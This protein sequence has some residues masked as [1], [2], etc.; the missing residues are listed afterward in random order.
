MVDDAQAAAAAVR[1][2]AEQQA[3]MQSRAE[4]QEESEQQ[5]AMEQRAA[6]EHMCRAQ[7]RAAEAEQAQL[8]QDPDV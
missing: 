4:Q 3:Q 5:A 2:P 6:A 1:V 8:Q 7:W